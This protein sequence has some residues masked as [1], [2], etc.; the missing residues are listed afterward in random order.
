MGLGK[1]EVLGRQARYKEDAREDALEK[2]MFLFH[3][4]MNSVFTVTPFLVGP[5]AADMSIFRVEPSSKESIERFLW[6]LATE[7]QSRIA[8]LKLD[9]SKKRLTKKLQA[10]WKGICVNIYIYK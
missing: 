4:D 5:I 7:N 9:V 6:R 1:R 3:Q 10:Q 2:Q 8:K